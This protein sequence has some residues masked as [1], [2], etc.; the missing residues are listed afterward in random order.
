MKQI[1][2]C[3]EVAI[4]T[5]VMF[6]CSPKETVKCDGIPYM[7]M[8]EI[9]ENSLAY[10]GEQKKVFNSRLLSDAE[11]MGVWEHQ[12]Q[13][14][15]LALSDE[16]P[17]KGKYS[18][19]L[20]AP[21]R[22]TEPVPRNGRAW[23]TSDAFYK[24]N[25]ENWTVDDWN[26][27]SFWIYPDMPGWKNVTITMTFHNDGEE[28][29]PWDYAPNGQSTIIIE[30]Q[31]WN[32]VNWEVAH[33]G[34]DKVTG[35]TIAYSVR[36][37][38]RSAS[39]NV[40]FFID[41]VYLEKVQAEHFEGWDVASGEI[42]YN[43]AGYT[44]GYPKIAFTS[45][46]L[47][48]K[49][50]LKD[51]TSGKVVKEGVVTAQTMPTGTF[52]MMD[53]SEVDTE[54]TYVLEVG[55]LKTKPFTIGAFSDVYRSSIIKTINHFYTQRCGTNMPGIHDACHLDWLCFHGDKS[56]PV[57]GGW[58][59]A[60]DL[61][62]GT[63]NTSEAAYSMMMLAEKLKN[64]DPVISERLLEEAEWG[65]AWILRTRFGDG[66]RAV[67][68]TKDFWTDGIIGTLDDFNSTARKD[69][70]ANLVSATTEAVAAISFK[71]RNPNLS[72]YALKAA[73][74]DYKFGVEIE[75]D[76]MSVELAGAALNAA[77]ALYDATS[78][79]TYKKAAIEHADYML[80]CQQQDV[81]SDM[82]LKGFF[83]CTPEKKEI[84]H[85]GHRGHEQDV[86][87]G[88]VKLSK[89]FPTEAGEWKK[90]LQLYADYYKNI[91]AHTA[92][93]YMIPAG[94]YDVASAKNE[95]DAI[96]I[97]NGI[98]LNERYYI[99]RFPVWKEY[100]GN[101]GT[102][103]TQ[104]TGLAVV[105]N[106]LQDKELSNIAYHAFDWHLGVNPFAQ[107]LMYGEGYRFAALFT[108]SS[109]DL[110]GGLPVGVHSHFHGDAPYWPTE[111]LWTWK[112][113]WVHPSTRWLM[114]ASSF[115]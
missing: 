24:V 20:E 43:H 35:I 106:F 2:N 66:Y 93:Y 14:G 47:G 58:H 41:E 44:K 73:V 10:V 89:L 69:P 9:H 46:N 36:G 17:Y 42:A 33:L 60:G 91:T 67:W 112:E 5:A 90:A 105:A 81:T 1:V 38:E 75:P 61:S 54:G 32:K 113:V 55:K 76:K 45:E 100:R 19:L 115:M 29:V 88:L 103:L 21:T 27:I 97:R 56:L 40:R 80:K 30:N 70:Q 96:Q 12:G 111:S 71:D 28:K 3:I 7:P 85:Y 50:V 101:S 68:N 107:S 72:A 23:G 109:G 84:L 79:A 108:L 62:Q 110:V 6:S 98:K 48:E 86:V 64:S 11:T 63:V 74:E 51:H 94:V 13:Y 8:E 18:L 92:P 59:D 57:H 65:M 16:K 82:P 102:T 25:N 53:F 87:V 39:Q 37:G 22:S 34:R 95:E 104:A 77:L 78:D 15:S 52:Q 26:R 31:K 83:Y 4:I 114:M 49:Y 99:K